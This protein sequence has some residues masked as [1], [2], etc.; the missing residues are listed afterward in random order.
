MTARKPFELDLET[1]SRLVGP[2]TGVERL[3]GGILSSVF[4]VRRADGSSVVVKV[5]PEEERW[6]LEKEVYV[7]GRLGN[8]AAP[9]ASVLGRDDDLNA[10]V[11]T[12]LEGVHVSSLELDE[13]AIVA[14]NRQIGA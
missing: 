11:L 10:L 5:Y 13:D 1:A 6:K 12:Q 7:Y 14:V 2:A 8:V 3:T 4:A 9:I